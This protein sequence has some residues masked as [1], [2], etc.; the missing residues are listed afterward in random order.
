MKILPIGVNDI[1]YDKFDED[2]S[3]TKTTIC[4]KNIIWG[5][6]YFD[7]EGTVEGVNHKTGER[8][9][10]TFHLKDSKKDSS[11][12]GKGFDAQGIQRFEI[13]GTWL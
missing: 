6:L 2:I 1:H 4:A 13:E 3:I 5:G 11:L 7:A 8:V 10:L 9:E 12:T